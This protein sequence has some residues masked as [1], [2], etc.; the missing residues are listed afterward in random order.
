MRGE[1]E[2]WSPEEGDGDGDV[3]RHSKNGGSS[4]ASVLG[5]R[6]GEFLWRAE[7]SGSLES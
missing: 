6:G 5:V 7:E 3:M 1:R 2:E 4:R